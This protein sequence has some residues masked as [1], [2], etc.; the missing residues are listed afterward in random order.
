MRKNEQINHL[1][2]LELNMNNIVQMA[3][4]ISIPF[5]TNWQI[6]QKLICQMERLKKM[7]DDTDDKKSSELNS[8]TFPGI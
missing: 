5:N 1:I 2:D 3:P 6:Q 8:D 4:F 7:D